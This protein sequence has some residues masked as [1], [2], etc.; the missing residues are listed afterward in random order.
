[1]IDSTIQQLFQDGWIAA[2]LRL[3]FVALLYLF[4]FLVLRVTA[5]ELVTLAKI[6]DRDSL[7]DEMS[8][9][10]LDAAQSSLVIGEP[11]P[12]F[13]GMTLGRDTGNDLVIDDP[14]TSAFHAE[15]HFSRD[16]WWVRDL[17]SSNGTFLNDEPVRAVVAIAPNDVLQCGRVRFRMVT[18]FAFRD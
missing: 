15:L 3:A 1:V 11:R 14:H 2:G 5:R 8:L 18:S 7:S 13:P 12:V 6:N 10:V 16:R 4:L 17:E 9:V